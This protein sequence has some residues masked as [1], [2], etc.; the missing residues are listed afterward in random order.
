MDDRGVERDRFTRESRGSSVCWMV[1]VQVGD[2]DI[3]V[4]AQ[5]L[6]ISSGVGH[7]GF[8]VLLGFVPLRSFHE[9]RFLRAAFMM[10]PPSLFSRSTTVPSANP[11]SSLSSCGINTLP[12]SSTTLSIFPTGIM[13][14]S[15][16]KAHRAV[17][18]QESQLMTREEIVEP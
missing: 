16:F 15:V 5:M 1:G 9:D 14:K 8:A 6:L 13:G 10:T 17:I 3:G 7:S 11:S 4:Y 12:R 2:E 18:E